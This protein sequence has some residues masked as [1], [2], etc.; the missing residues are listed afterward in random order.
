M[1]RNPSR[2]RSLATFLATVAL[3]LVSSARARAEIPTAAQ[4]PFGK[5]LLAAQQQEW[6]IALQSFQE[7]RKAAPDAPEIYY[8]L[9]LTESKLP[10]RELRA[11]AWF[12]AYL[13]MNPNAL[14]LPAVK[15]VI[16]SL[17]IKNEGNIR[18]LIKTL[19][20]S[21]EL[22][23]KPLSKSSYEDDIAVAQ[24]SVGEFAGAQK[25]IDDALLVFST[26]PN[27]DSVFKMNL[28]GDE[29]KINRAVSGQPLQSTAPVPIISSWIEIVDHEL[30]LPMFL[31]PADYFK[32][33]A[34]SDDPDRIS[35]GLSLALR[36]TVDER[37]KIASMLK[38]QA[39]QAPPR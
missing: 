24:L 22:V 23:N 15:N 29:F 35:F 31:D 8:N 26:I 12:G 28:R 18:R 3:I 17:Q 10:G 9:G 19:Q 20:S 25:T 11:I 5:G 13:A 1:K 34:A 16:A 2:T 38:Q 14:N 6:E 7:A 36:R 27:A 33:W 21:V 32:S 39:Q 4:A 37:D 30:N